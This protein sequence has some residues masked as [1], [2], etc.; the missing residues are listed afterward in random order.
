M[1]Y[2]KYVLA[3]GIYCGHWQWDLLRT[4]AMGFIA[5]LAFAE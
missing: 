4:L 5:G 3:M 2:A 1:K